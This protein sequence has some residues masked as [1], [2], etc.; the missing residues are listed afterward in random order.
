MPPLALSFWRWALALVI[1]IPFSARSFLQQKDLMLKHWKIIL[2]LGA[3]GIAGFSAFIYMALSR[4]TVTNT[5]LVNA[6]NPIFI[7]IFA[8]VGFRE[9]VSLLQIVG[10]GL[11]LAGLF[12]IISRGNPAFIRTL[13]FTRGDL[14]PLAASVCW[15]LYTVLLRLYPGRTDSMGFLTALFTAGLIILTPLYIWE[16]TAI[17][18]IRIGAAS[19]GGTLYLGIFPSIFAYVC[20]NRGVQSVGAGRAGVFIY[21]IPVV[22]IILA[23]LL[24]DERLE[25]YHPPG[26]ALIALGVLMTTYFG[27]K[28]ISESRQGH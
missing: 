8:W 17:Q 22:S 18:S 25:S 3:I 4:T 28:N 6:T 5:V 19:I 24:F 7:V 10:I 14:F 23:F 2:L 12:W 16:H 13:Q 15:A 27:K 1:L 21:L 9:R 20:W 11:S 26:M